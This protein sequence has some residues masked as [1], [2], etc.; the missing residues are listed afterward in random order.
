V[1]LFIVLYKL[2][3]TF[4]CDHSNESSLAPFQCQL[5]VE[6]EMLEFSCPLLILAALM[7]VKVLISGEFS[8]EKKW[9]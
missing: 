9:S 1:V 5:L 6:K 7:G 8:R 4:G 3:L 2:V